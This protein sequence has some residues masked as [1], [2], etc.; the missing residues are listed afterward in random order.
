MGVMERLP[1][2]H[3]WHQRRWL[4]ALLLGVTGM[5][6]AV[7]PAHASTPASARRAQTDQIDIRNLAFA[8]NKP[9]VP[10]GA[11][12]VWS[13]RDDEP[14]LVTSPG[15]GFAASPALDISESYAATFAKPGTYTYFC[16]LHR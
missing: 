12:L 7:H 6:S 5:S 9:T 4:C 10:A 16:S 15:A 13:N 8:P 2:K 3:R 14:Y 11:R 1:A